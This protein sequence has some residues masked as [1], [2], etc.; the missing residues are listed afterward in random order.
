MKSGPN[1]SAQA[2]RAA[3]SIFPRRTSV[4]NGPTMGTAT[5]TVASVRASTP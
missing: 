4:N 3:V 5:S 2:R 1:P